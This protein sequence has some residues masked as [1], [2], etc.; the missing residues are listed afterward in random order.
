MAKLGPVIYMRIPTKAANAI[1]AMARAEQ[2]KLTDMLR[3]LLEEALKARTGVE[4]R[5]P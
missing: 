4:A 3:I 1:N 5:K 2:R